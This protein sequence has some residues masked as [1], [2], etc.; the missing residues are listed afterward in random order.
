LLKEA[1]GKR[2]ES[3]PLSKCLNA[4]LDGAFAKPQKR[5]LY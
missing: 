5:L 4:I 3:S 1:V 2:F